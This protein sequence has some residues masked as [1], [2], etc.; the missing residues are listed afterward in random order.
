MTR[1]STMPLGSASWYLNLHRRMSILRCYQHRTTARSMNRAVQAHARVV[2]RP[3]GMHH[4][5]TRLHAHV[6]HLMTVCQA[7][8]A[9][10][11]AREGHHARRISIRSL[12]PT[13]GHTATN[14][15]G[16]TSVATQ[17]VLD[18]RA[19][20]CSRAQDATCVEHCGV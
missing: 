6:S 20:L 8:H 5:Y 12:S 1:C 3:S 14:P 7:T 9:A 4:V 13:E 15:R 10:R 19:I 17:S 11:R 2:M 16:N 18:A